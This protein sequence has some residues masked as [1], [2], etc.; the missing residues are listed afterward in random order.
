[1]S[2]TSLRAFGFAMSFSVSPSFLP[3]AAK[4]SATTAD[5]P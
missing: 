3:S 1:M 4:Y 2:R 5:S